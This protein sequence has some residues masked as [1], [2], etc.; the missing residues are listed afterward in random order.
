MFE[1]CPLDS[2]Y[3]GGD[4]T[5]NTS[6]DYGYSP[7]YRNTTLRTVVITDKETEIS[8]NEFYGCTNLQNFTVGD[9]VTTFGDWAFSG[10]SSLKSL[11]FGTQFSTIGKEAFSDCA[12]V[13]KI[14]SKATTP[15]TCG[16]QALDD[17]YKW[18]C[19]LYVPTG[20]LAAYKAADQWKE[21]FFIKEG[22]G[23]DSPV[24][25]ELQKCETPTISYNN[26]QLMF[27]CATEGAICQSTI[28]DSDIMSYT[29]NEVQLGATYNISVY[30]VK[31]GYENSDVATA[32]L[33]WIDVEPQSIATEVM[34]VRAL[35]VMIQSNNGVVTVSGVNDGTMVAVYTVS[36]QMVGSAKASSNQAAITT[37]LRK[38]E[39]AIVKIG[40]KAVKVVMH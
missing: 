23:G 26:G 14:V 11:S 31:A 34:E 2:V 20:C 37:N 36:G 32:T 27:D 30:A 25:P 38:G 19:T 15:P 6:S 4:I 10:C 28:T 33:C 8:P 39:I 40:E 17:I 12:S 21:F 13:T 16:T 29:V 24:I 5:Y 7:F 22:N 3:I 18:D 9:G 1:S 35:A